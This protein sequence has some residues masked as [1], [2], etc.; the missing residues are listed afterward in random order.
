MSRQGVTAALAKRLRHSTF[1]TLAPLDLFPWIFLL[2]L[3]GLRLVNA[4]RISSINDSVATSGV[5]PLAL[6]SMLPVVLGVV[7]IR[8]VLTRWPSQ[9]L[10]AGLAVAF[11]PTT[12]LT[13][14]L[15][16][17][18]GAPRSYLGLILEM[19]LPLQTA[20]PAALSATIVAGIAIVAAELAKRAR[21]STFATLAP[22]D[23][24]P[25]TFLLAFLGLRLVTAV[26][27]S[28]IND[29]VATSGVVPLALAS[30]LPVALGVVVI[31]EVLTRWPSQRLATGLAVAFYPTTFLTL[32]L[33][34]LDGAPRSYVGLILEMPL[35]LPLQTAV[36]EA[37]SVTLVAGLAIAAGAPLSAQMRGIREVRKETAALSRAVESSQTTLA[38]EKESLR[39]EL[40]ATFTPLI[41]D[42]LE[43]I[44]QAGSSPASALKLSNDV[45]TSVSGAVQ[46]FVEKLRLGGTPVNTPLLEAAAVLSSRKGI[47]LR[48]QTGGSMRPTLSAIVSLIVALNILTVPGNLVS[49][50]QVQRFSLMVTLFACVYAYKR[51]WDWGLRFAPN[52]PVLLAG[53][54]FFAINTVMLWAVSAGGIIFLQS[55]NW[56]VGGGL[57][58]LSI[59]FV[60]LMLSAIEVGNGALS[61]IALAREDA[62]ARM[63]A[64]KVRQATDLWHLRRQAALFVHGRVQSALIA[65][66][67]RL[68]IDPGSSPAQ[69][70][71]IIHQVINDLD[72]YGAS[73]SDTASLSSFLQELHQTWN[74]VVALDTTL[75]EEDFTTVN[76]SES[77]LAMM[78]EVIREAVTNGVR[79]GNAK[80]I[81]ILVRRSGPG[82]ANIVVTDDGQDSEG[83]AREGF[84]TQFLR[85]ISLE[86][87]RTPQGGM[88]VLEVTVPI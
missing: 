51:A 52:M 87:S 10:A 25:W 56:S 68:S 26:R 4:V 38:T 34:G 82:I 53:L 62:R 44:N 63:Q 46:P 32:L 19:P 13:L 57:D 41:D 24:F 33:P 79:H 28:S 81:S 17:L 6:V 29:S 40:K 14:F 83:Q 65:T 16:G 73:L 15:P 3:L 70:R 76:S 88:T 31:R 67:M 80:N 30:M 74:Q 21:H 86:W 75:P 42:L 78:K 60:A 27:I 66:A 59:A 2:A 48:I 55:S 64:Q 47:L 8:R 11:Y 36:F 37:L 39:H 71:D 7:V 35:P 54:I 23:L 43:K 69:A 72:D 22:V 9:R 12:F 49:L 20:V 77:S 1:A 50:D 5:F 45:K 84:G 18:D 58:F 85:E 61:A